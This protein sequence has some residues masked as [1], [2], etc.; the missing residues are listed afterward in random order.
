MRVFI[1]GTGMAARSVSIALNENTKLL[2]Y[3]DNDKTKQG[4]KYLGKQVFSPEVLN[5]QNFDF[6][7]IGA[8]FKYAEISRQI[9]KMGIG[10]DKIIQ[11]FNC[12]RLMPLAFFYNDQYIDEKKYQDVF[13]NYVEIR[14]YLIKDTV[15]AKDNEIEKLKEK[16]NIY[17]DQKNSFREKDNFRLLL[18]GSGLYDTYE[19]ARFGFVYDAVDENDTTAVLNKILSFKPDAI[20]SYDSVMRAK[21]HYDHKN[22][23]YININDYGPYI[24][25]LPYIKV[26]KNEIHLYD[27]TACHELLGQL[28]GDDSIYQHVAYKKMVPGVSLLEQKTDIS[29]TFDTDIVVISASNSSISKTKRYI[30]WLCMQWMCGLENNCTREKMKIVLYE[31]LDI[32]YLKMDET[33]EFIEDE[34]IYMQVFWE[35]MGDD[36]KGMHGISKDNSQ[37]FSHLLCMLIGASAYRRL[38]IKWIIERGYKVQLWGE[39][40]KNEPGME[41]YYKGNIDSRE[42]LVRVYNRSKISLF[43]NV[44]LGV[45]VSVFEMISSKSLCLAYQNSNTTMASLTDYFKDRESIVFYKNRQELFEQID[46]YLKHMDKRK[47]V[48]DKGYQII[49]EQNLFWEYQFTRTVEKAIELAKNNGM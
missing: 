25:L 18:L 43:T 13:E 21:E 23:L 26:W 16:L 9:E 38:I 4:K 29:K 20:A 46:Y 28:Y 11:F 41:A 45:H 17:Y 33:G 30:D 8:Y 34:K 15:E 32:F 7:I 2:G 39:S 5:V 22:I 3:I 27:Y 10:V 37:Y 44:F 24:Y 49:R 31:M 12:T 1:W 19:L 36:L 40:W 47:E 35:L 6:V 42:E 14:L 48:I